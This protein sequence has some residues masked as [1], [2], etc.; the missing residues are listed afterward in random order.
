MKEAERPLAFLRLEGLT[1]DQPANLEEIIIR[2]R[3]ARELAQDLLLHYRGQETDP[4]TYWAQQISKQVAAWNGVIDKYLRPVEILMSPP[5]QLMSLGEATHESRREALAATFSLRNIA[6]E[7]ISGLVP[8][9]PFYQRREDQEISRDVREWLDLL[10]TEVDRSRRNASEQLAQLDEL[11]AQSRELEDGMGLRFLYDEERRIF[12]IGY[13]VAERRL[14]NSFYDLLAS[15]ARLTSFLAIARGE[16]PVE[17]WWALSRPFGS[18]YGRLPL[19]SWSGTMFEY[20]MPLLF[21]QTHENS[22]LDRACYDAVHCQIGYGRQNRRAV[23]HFGIGLQRAR[24]TQ[25]LSIPSL[26]R[27]G[28]GIETW[29]GRRPGG[30]AICRCARTWRGTGRCDEE[31]ATA[32]C[33]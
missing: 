4:R 28:A 30:C 11:I 18:A 5:A 10:A 7:G 1:R 20:L 32:R 31:S 3:A 21:T 15:E 17:H 22:L 9:L 13:Q 23:G 25:R 16:V 29:A 6:I 8:L 12:A 26:W 24:P 14:D 19:L 27:P 33:S 2:I